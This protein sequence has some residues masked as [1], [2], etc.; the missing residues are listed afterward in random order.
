MPTDSERKDSTEVKFDE[1]ALV[2]AIAAA[3]RAYAPDVRAFTRRLLGAGVRVGAASLIEQ[4][5]P[6]CPPALP[7]AD[8]PDEEGRS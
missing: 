5:H 6:T 3:A 7:D 8:G 1:A 4:R 2:L